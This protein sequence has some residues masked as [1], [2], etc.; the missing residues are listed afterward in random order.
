VPVGNEDFVGRLEAKTNVKL[1][2]MREE[3]KCGQVEMRSVVN[4][5][6]VNMKKD[7]KETVSCQVTATCLDSKELNPEDMKS[8]VEHQEVPMEETAV[9]SSGT[10]KK[11][12]RD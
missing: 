12:H 7:R 5:W 11:Q 10:M 6:I 9:K 8:E 2:Q 4:A 1:K 3:I